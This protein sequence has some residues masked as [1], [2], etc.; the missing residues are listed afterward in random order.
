MKQLV[1]IHHMTGS[2][3]TANIAI[4]KNGLS[5]IDKS[6]HCSD[7]SVIKGF[8]SQLIDMDNWNHSWHLNVSNAQF[9]SSDERKRVREILQ[10]KIEDREKEIQ[11]LKN[12]IQILGRWNIY[13]N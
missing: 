10:G 1:A 13:T 7:S 4:D 8:L 12:G 2:P 11:K 6:E 3:T 5:V 9:K